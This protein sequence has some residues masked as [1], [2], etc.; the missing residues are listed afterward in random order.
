MEVGLVFLF[1]W[2]DSPK[3]HSQGYYWHYSGREAHEGFGQPLHRQV[4]RGGTEG[5]CSLYMLLALAQ[6]WQ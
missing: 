2:L 6:L 5:H 3:A 4:A 1:P